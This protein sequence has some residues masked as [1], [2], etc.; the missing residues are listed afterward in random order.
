MQKSIGCF[1]LQTGRTEI[2]LSTV[3]NI[4]KYSS[5]HPREKKLIGTSK[6]HNMCKILRA[7]I[8]LSDSIPVPPA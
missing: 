6:M 1:F 8:M 2:V 7:Y 5:R 3:N 4:H